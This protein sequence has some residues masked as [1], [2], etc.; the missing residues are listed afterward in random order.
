MLSLQPLRLKRVR[1]WFQDQAYFDNVIQTLS[2]FGK[3]HP[4]IIARLPAG[5][6][7]GE[8]YIEG[9]IPA[10]AEKEVSERITSATHGQCVVR[11]EETRSD[12]DVPT[13]TAHGRFLKPFERLVQSFGIPSPWEIDPTFLVALSFILLFGFMFADIGHGLILSMFGLLVYTFSGKLKNQSGLTSYVLQNGS[14]LIVCGVS[15]IIGGVLLGEFFGYHVNLL[16]SKIM[17]PQ[18]LGIV[19]PFSPIE[20]PMMMF[21]LSLLIAAIHISLGLTLNLLN[22]LSNRKYRAAFFEP[23]VWLWFYLGLMSGVFTYRLDLGAWAQSPLL[24]WMII[25][26]LTLMLFGKLVIEGLDGLIFFIEAVIST[27]SNTISYLR[28]LAL[29]LVHGVMSM[30]ILTVGGGNPAVTALGSLAII[31]LEGLLIFIH[32]TRLV[33]VEWFSKFYR[34]EGR[35]FKN[36]NI[37]DVRAISVGHP[38]REST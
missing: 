6:R 16:P 23:V 38:Y 10:M 17:L 15:G 18:P 34:G 8:S 3:F 1:V 14:L 26:P 13:L 21:K 11:L 33:W 32:T 12:Q 27:V 28:I 19:F 9:W 29:S 22:K 5:S 2:D 7:Q 24:L 31:A 25:L 30:M 36:F 4:S 37:T 35:M 20:E